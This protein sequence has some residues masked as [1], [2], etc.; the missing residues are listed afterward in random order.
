MWPKQKLFIGKVGGADKHNGTV[1]FKK[2]KQFLNTN[3]YS[4]LEMS[5]D[6]NYILY[7]NVFHFYNANVNKTSVAAL[8]NYLSALLSTTCCE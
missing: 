3:I 8:D 1:R 6:Q 2:C 4:Y 7:L 5:G